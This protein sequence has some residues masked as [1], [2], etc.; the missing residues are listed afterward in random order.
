MSNGN[1]ILTIGYK[2][3]ISIEH[4]YA[5]LEQAIEKATETIK[6]NSIEYLHIGVLNDLRCFA[7]YEC[8]SKQLT[9]TPIGNLL[10]LKERQQP[11][12]P[13]FVKIVNDNFWDLI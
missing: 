8:H 6:S 7:H 4:Q 3:A 5:T 9:L 13:E 12:D 10:L 1:I 11:L 2:P